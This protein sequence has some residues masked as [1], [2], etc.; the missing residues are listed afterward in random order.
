MRFN[1]KKL[2]LMTRNLALGFPSYLVVKS[3]QR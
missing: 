3:R 1:F 2:N